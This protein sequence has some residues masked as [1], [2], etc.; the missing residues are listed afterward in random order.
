MDNIFCPLCKDNV[1]KSDNNN[2]DLIK[3]RN[4][5]FK[6]LICNKCNI[7]FC[8][9]LCAF[10]QKKIYMKK[11]PIN[12]KYNGL[13]GFNIECPYKS[14]NNVLYFTE[15][16]KCKRIQKH[17][18]HICEGNTII[19]QYDDC[20]CN[21]LEINCP[22]KYCP[23]LISMEKPMNN[24]K[25]SL[26][27]MLIHENTIMYQ[28]INCCYC[29]RPIVYPSKKGKRNK[30]IECQKVICPYK[31]C[32]KMF[33]RIICPYCNDEIYISNGWYEMGAKIKCKTCNKYFGKILCYS[34][35]K[36]NVCKDNFFKFGKMICGMDNCLK[37]N[38][39]IN[40][41]FC[42]KLNIFNNKIPV[43]GQ[44]IKC[45]YCKNIFN[46]ICCPFC[47]LMN[48]FPLADFSYGKTYKCQYLTCLKE[49]QFLMCPNCLLNSFTNE[50]EEGIILKCKKCN[51]IFMNWGCPFCKSNIMSKNC[52]LKTGEMVKC[53]SKKCG[54]I[55]SFTRCSK[56]KK[57]IFSKENESIFGKSI[58]C[59]YPNCGEYTLITQCPHCDTKIEYQGQRNSYHE[60]E[61]LSCQNCK[62]NYKFK[63]NNKVY[64]KDLSILEQIE[65]STIDFGVG[66]VDENYLFK[67]SLFFN[68]SLYCSQFISNNDDEET[69]YSSK[70]EIIEKNKILKECV[71]CYN[72]LKESVFYPCGH[73]CAC[74]NCALIVFTINKKCP[75]CDMEA[76]CI[77]KKVYD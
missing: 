29:L 27:Y 76:K 7:K 17:K 67:K 64:E 71:V 18:K 34:C 16:I 57:L 4:Y 35:N 49:F 36:L 2:F 43:N 11:N 33:N 42:R 44:V 39:M 72:N 40:C 60:G 73:R 15:C 54:K 70:E 56:C 38:Y 31:D 59:P 65:G 45:G 47:R 13:I 77:I 69:D 20:K 26:G 19:C 9:I 28:V 22:A 23:D 1:K 41:I 46:E 8:Y 66:E 37:E 5:E 3:K 32:N 6:E 14:C 53:P 25:L 51:L 52:N 58:K 21:Y 10:C 55:Y 50:K 30:Y 63:Q 74:Y 12:S 62:K 68:K 61:T 24:N 48:P 75:K